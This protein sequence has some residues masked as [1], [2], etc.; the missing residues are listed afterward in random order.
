M[1]FPVTA[2]VPVT[3]PIRKVPVTAKATATATVTV[4]TTVTAAVYSQGA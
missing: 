2:K 4:T 3:A 1:W